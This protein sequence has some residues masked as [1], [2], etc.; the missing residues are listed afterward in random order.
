MSGVEIL[1]SSHVIVIVYGDDICYHQP[2]IIFDDS[3]RDLMELLDVL[4]GIKK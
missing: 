1:K 2:N 4:V 3:I